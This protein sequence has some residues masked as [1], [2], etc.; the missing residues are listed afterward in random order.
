MVVEEQCIQNSIFISTWTHT[1]RS[2]NKNKQ[3]QTWYG[4]IGQYIKLTLEK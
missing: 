2:L 1:I 4:K 3:G